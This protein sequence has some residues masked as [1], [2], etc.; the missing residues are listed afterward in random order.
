MVQALRISFFM[1]V[2]G[3]LIAPVFL[4]CAGL[5]TPH[6]LTPDQQLV[7]DSSDIV[8]LS[9]LADR[10]R[11]GEPAGRE[12]APLIDAVLGAQT[13]RVHDA[14][15]TPQ[16]GELIEAAHD[17]GLLSESQW[18]QYLMQGA[19]FRPEVAD[20]IRPGDPIWLR[21]QLVPRLGPRTKLLIEYST[22][23]EMDQ[24]YPVR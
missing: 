14:V 11:R 24:R 13:G 4:L 10:V 2:C 12:L 20:P 17:R 16:G 22:E 23:L 7:E 15:W 8:L 3:A 19:T 6:D 21:Y 9:T 5:F 1:I 18:D